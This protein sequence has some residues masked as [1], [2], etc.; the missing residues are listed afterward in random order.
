MKAVL[1][2]LFVGSCMI[3]PIAFT[4]AYVYCR[5]LISFV[6]GVHPELYEEKGGR[7]SLRIEKGELDL[8]SLQGPGYGYSSSIDFEARTPLAEWKPNPRGES[9]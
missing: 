6:R 4:V 7:I 1:I 3:A 5:M 2:V 9:H 8:S